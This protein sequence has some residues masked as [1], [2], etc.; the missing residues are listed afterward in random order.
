[1]LYRSVGKMPA[2]AAP[3]ITTQPALMHRKSGETLMQKLLWLLILS[4]VPALGVT[5]PLRVF[6]SV[7]P[8]KTF[9]E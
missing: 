7:L 1:M 8:V 5:E 2:K 6:A 4:L 3:A 9:I